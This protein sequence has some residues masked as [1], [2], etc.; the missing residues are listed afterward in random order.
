M[1]YENLYINYKIE[2]DNTKLGF[3]CDA[4]NKKQR[5]TVDA[6]S[7]G[8]YWN[9]IENPCVDEEIDN[10][11]LT[12]FKI[13]DVVSR[14]STSNK[15]Y[16]ILDPR[17]FELEI[18][19]DNLLNICINSKINNGL[20]EDE[21]VW[22]K[23]NSAELIL[24][25]SEQYKTYC[26]LKE[27]GPVD[28]I[29]GEYYKDSKTNVIYKYLGEY[30]KLIFNKNTYAF[31]NNEDDLLVVSKLESKQKLKMFV[32]ASD[33][34]LDIKRYDFISVSKSVSDRFVKTKESFVFDDSLLKEPVLTTKILA[35]KLIK[36][37]FKYLYLASSYSDVVFLFK[38]K[39][40]IKTYDF[41]SDE[42]FHEANSYIRYTKAEI[43]FNKITDKNYIDSITDVYSY[44]KKSIENAKTHSVVFMK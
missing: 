32:K 10:I 1:I 4:A 9:K 40:D 29:A 7:K 37:E 34:Y 36:N 17:G 16:R 30:T 33:A 8:N 25:S 23:N 39:N 44:D 6:W 31:R 42:N 2:Q 19:A 22:G 24:T 27:S 20:I 28:L 13:V 12:G 41:K 43:D 5:E 3:I 14:Y 11:P 21:C 15:W 35:K 18:S 38:D 26:E